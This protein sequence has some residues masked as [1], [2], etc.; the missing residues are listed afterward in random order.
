MA[1]ERIFPLQSCHKGQFE[2]GSSSGRMGGNGQQPIMASLIAHHFPHVSLIFSHSFAFV[3]ALT[4]AWNELTP[5]FFEIQVMWHRLRDGLLWRSQPEFTVFSLHPIAPHATCTR[6]S[7]CLA[8]DLIFQTYLFS[9]HLSLMQNVFCS[10][11]MPKIG[12]GRYTRC[13][14]ALT[15]QNAKG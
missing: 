10:F 3:A 6:S 8:S 7:L 11:F 1:L 14:E 15:C 9:L 2:S 12:H 5:I 13:R 4:S